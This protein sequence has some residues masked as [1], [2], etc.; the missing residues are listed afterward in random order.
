MDIADSVCSA[1]G[2]YTWTL[3]P[4]L[5]LLSVIYRFFKMF[6]SVLCLRRLASVWK[7]RFF[8]SSKHALLFWSNRCFPI[9]HIRGASDESS[10]I[11]AKNRKY[12]LSIYLVL[13]KFPCKLYWL[14]SSAILLFVCVS[15]LCRGLGYSI[16]SLHFYFLN[17]SLSHVCTQTHSLQ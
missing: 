8:F 9:G 7:V 13:L 5:Y 15:V 6:L 16:G 17:S 11:S 3:L 14:A 2:S 4:L 1:S 12:V 10:N